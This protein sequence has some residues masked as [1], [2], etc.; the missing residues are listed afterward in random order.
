LGDSDIHTLDRPKLSYKAG[1]DFFLQAEADI[2]ALSERPYYK[3]WSARSFAHTLL[4]G[5]FTSASL[6]DRAQAMALIFCGTSERINEDWGKRSRRCQHALLGLMVRGDFTKANEVPDEV[7]EAYRSVIRDSKETIKQ[8]DS[9]ETIGLSLDWLAQFGAPLIDLDPARVRSYAEGCYR[10]DDERASG[11]RSRVII[12]LASNGFFDDA[13]REFRLMLDD[14]MPFRN[15]ESV[16]LLARIVGVSLSPRE[17]AA[18]ALV[19]G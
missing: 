18:V 12:A 15:V 6:E 1:R 3:G 4:G 10:S 11:C 13:R 16:E 5:L 17:R 7:M 14:R 8:P 19:P 2:S 9:I